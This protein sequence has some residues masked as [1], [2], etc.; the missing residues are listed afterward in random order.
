M[1]AKRVLVLEFHQETDTFNPITTDLEAFRRR[2]YA[3]GEEAL[4]D[5]TNDSGSAG[6]T[7]AAIEEAGGE[8]IPTIFL[9]CTS[10][11]RVADSVFQLLTERLREHIASAGQIDAVCAALHGATCTETHSDACG[12]LLEYLGK[13]LDV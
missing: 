1:A 11:G 5:R 9:A 3:E 7:I 12:D 8:V 10:G 6:G 2:Y 13:H 4:R